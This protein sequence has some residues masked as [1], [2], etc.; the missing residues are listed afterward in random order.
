MSDADTTIKLFND[1]KIRTKWDSLKEKWYFSIIDVIKVLTESPRP[2]TY[3]SA[4]KTKLTDEWVR[5]G[6]EK[7]EDFAI[8]TN[9]ITKAWSGKT[10]KEYKTLKSLKKE[11]LRDNMTNVEL[12]LN[13]LAEVST[14]KLS[15]KQHK[16]DFDQSKQ[17]ARKWGGVARV[18][19]ETLET[20]LGEK[21]VTPKNAKQIHSKNQNQFD[22]QKMRNTYKEKFIRIK[23]NGHM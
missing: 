1:T 23:L 3:W 21:I 6:R 20:E 11:N 17:I 2:R 15:E 13:M 16:Q 4:L 19:K 10:I 18:A 5:V 8:L 9:E 22:S 12:I 14:K 7:Q